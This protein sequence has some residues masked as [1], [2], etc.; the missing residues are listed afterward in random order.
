[1][2]D[3]DVRLPR[4][5]I[6]TGIFPPDHGG[7]ATYVPEM[8]KAL[9]ETLEVIAVV[10]L[11][12]RLDH[13]DSAYPFRVIRIRRKVPRLLRVPR[14]ILLLRRLAAG[15][16]IVYLNGLV[17]EGI[18]AGKL[19]RRRPVVVKVVGDLIWE[20][21]RASGTS[22]ATI[23]EFQRHPG[24]LKWRL[25]RRLQCWYL[26]RADR[27]IT[28]SRYLARLVA[29]WTGRPERIACI[30]NAVHM[31]APAD[32]AGDKAYDLIT[33]ARLVPWKGLPELVELAARRGWR[34]LIVGDGPLRSAL[35]ERI[36]RLGAGDCAIMT[37]H[38]DRGAVPDLLR[39][40]RVFVLNSTYEG[41]PHVVL[42]AMAV[43][44]PVVATDA[45]GSGEVVRDGDTGRLVPA[46]DPSS[47][48]RAIAELLANPEV[49]D[50]LAAAAGRRLAA[51]FSFDRMVE[52]TAALLVRASC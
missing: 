4:L 41:L 44:T 49:A 15:A 47:L 26:A 16:D 46:G 27:I 19:L 29:S 32:A 52:Q 5:L 13:D 24:G 9:A 42:E 18:V 23:E 1:M 30:R 37:G 36:A 34:L 3:S 40:A 2:I 43:G 33:V 12:E 21:A 6:V 48:E 51:E 14:T 20:R 22:D 11:S 38:V 50:R 8:A 39:R 28:P 45:G 7:P 25:L 10:T 17:F 31:P 35:A